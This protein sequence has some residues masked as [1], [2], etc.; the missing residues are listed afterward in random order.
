MSK[1]SNLILILVC[2]LLFI[3]GIVIERYF[4]LYND[5]SLQQGVHIKVTAIN[6][7]KGFLILN[8]SLVIYGGIKRIFPKNK[9]HFYPNYFKVIK[10]IK[11]PYY[12][13]KKSNNDTLRI[14]KGDTFYFK[15]TPP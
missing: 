3:L 15:F 12:L 6:K 7:K 14:I 5:I 11:K 13:Y 9:H 10:K 4:Y 1:K 8:D 2:L